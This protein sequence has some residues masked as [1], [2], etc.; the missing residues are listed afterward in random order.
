MDIVVIIVQWLDKLEPE[1][2][3]KLPE[4]KVSLDHH[5]KKSFQ[6]LLELSI[7][8]YIMN[9]VSRKQFSINTIA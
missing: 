8:L 3:E 7:D 9:I 6:F 2:P 1:N 5:F 4:E